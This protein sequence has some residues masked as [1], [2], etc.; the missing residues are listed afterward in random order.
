M[1]NLKVIGV[2]AII[3]IIAMLESPMMAID[4]FTVDYYESVPVGG[5]M[6]N[7]VVSNENMTLEKELI[8]KDIIDGYVVE[9][10]QE[11]EVYRDQKGEVVRSIPTSKY[12]YLRYLITKP[13]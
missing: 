7:E 4:Q 1:K 9:T 10:Y 3:G 2:I 13:E 11:F 8:S 12:D 5:N 6:E